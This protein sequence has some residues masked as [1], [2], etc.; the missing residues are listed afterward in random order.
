MEGSIEPVRDANWPALILS[1]LIPLTIAAG[2]VYLAT[3]PDWQPSTVW[4]YGM[5]FLIPL[6]F[7]RALI[8]SFL[9][10]AYKTGKGPLAAVQSFLLSMAILL[11]LGIFYAITQGGISATFGFLTDP[12][13]LQALGLPILIM[14]I[15]GVI[16]IWTF[17]GDPVWQ[18]ECIEAISEDSID[19]LSLAV[20]RLPL[21]IAPIAGVLVWMK[22]NDFRIAA[23]LPEPSLDLLRSAGLLYAA[24]YFA[25]KAVL[26]AHVHSAHFA[27]TGARVLQAAWIQRIVKPKTQERDKYRSI[28]SQTT[29]EGY[30]QEPV[31][32]V[33][34]FEDDVIRSLK[35]KSSTDVSPGQT[36]PRT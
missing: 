9:G 35:E 13:V 32:S 14:V 28:N 21:V 5:A 7:I 19:W 18:A 17:R 12:F 29:N 31:K 27:A 23:W 6:E 25:V 10:D 34:A 22:S 8:L 1:A 26:V 30:R 4:I 11:A 15:D 33:L 20:T 36:K 24:L 2:F 3:L 16:G